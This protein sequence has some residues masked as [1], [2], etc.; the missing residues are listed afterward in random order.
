M[1]ARGFRGG[2]PSVRPSIETR[3]FGE[4]RQMIRVERMLQDEPPHSFQD[5][6][7]G[8]RREGQAADF[9]RQKAKALQLWLRASLSRSDDYWASQRVDGRRRSAS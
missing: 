3:S 5:C 7:C 8:T 1:T 2:P 9:F 6:F 4:M